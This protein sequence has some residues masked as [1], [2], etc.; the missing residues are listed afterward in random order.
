MVNGG[1]FLAD[2]GK[3]CRGVNAWSTTVRNSPIM[4][5]AGAFI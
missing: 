1:V 5:N 2:R 3:N 4:V